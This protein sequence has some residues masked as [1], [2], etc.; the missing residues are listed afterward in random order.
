MTVKDFGITKDGIATKLYT[1]RNNNLE[2]SVTDFGST[3][4]SIV[5]PDRNNKPTDIV[6]GYDDVSGYETDDGYYFGC[7]VGRC[8]NRIARGHFVLNNKIGRAHV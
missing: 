1:L 2:I 8:A 7:N 3:L 4:V 6:L 5:V